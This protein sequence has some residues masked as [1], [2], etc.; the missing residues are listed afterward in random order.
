MLVFSGPFSGSLAVFSSVDYCLSSSAWCL[1]SERQK[2]LCLICPFI[3]VCGPATGW[4]PV[5][6]SLVS[7]WQPH[8]PK[9]DTAGWENWLILN[10]NLELNSV[11]ICFTCL[12]VFF[13]SPALPWRRWL[14]WCRPETA[15]S[16]GMRLPWHRWSSLIPTTAAARWLRRAGAPTVSWCVVMTQ[17]QMWTQ[18]QLRSC[19]HQ[20]RNQP[21]TVLRVW[22][23]RQ[24][25]SSG[26]ESEN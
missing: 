12:G 23:S 24:T 21:E 18:L 10:L 15:W 16:S 2:L 9:T 8:D 1:W 19:W 17:I 6:S 11:T 13:L 7:F 4:R 14:A 25:K 22:L 3:F 26:I 20:G 5:Q